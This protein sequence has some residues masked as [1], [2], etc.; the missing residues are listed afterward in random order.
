MKKGTKLSDVTYFL[1][2]REMSHNPVYLTSG[3][4]LRE[5]VR[6]AAAHVPTMDNYSKVYR[7]MRVQLGVYMGLF[8]LIPAT[9]RPFH[10]NVTITSSHISQA[11]YDRFHALVETLPKGKLDFDEK[12]KKPRST[13]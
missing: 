12:P 8:V 3:P 11:D 10:V 13:S 6:A 4:S 7:E 1:E 2:I 5:L 9:G